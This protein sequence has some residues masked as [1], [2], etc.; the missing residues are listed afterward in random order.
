MALDTIKSQGKSI[1]QL[2]ILNE[3]SLT[4]KLSQKKMA[5]ERFD[6]YTP[7]H[8]GHFKQVWVYANGEG[9]HEGAHVYVFAICLT[10]LCLTT[11]V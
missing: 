6:W 10:E 7:V 3:V 11:A 1:K 9:E 5:K 4:F 2:Q 8:Y